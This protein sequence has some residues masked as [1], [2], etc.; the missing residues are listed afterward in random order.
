MLG[1]EDR[2]ADSARKVLEQSPERV[3]SAGRSA[4]GQYLDRIGGHGP[5]GVPLA[6][7]ARRRHG[8]CRL[9]GVTQ[10]LELG[11]EDFGKA[12]VEAADAGLG[13]RIG[14]S[15]G[16]RG[17]GLLGP[18]FS[19]RRDDH[20][21]SAAGRGDNPRN[22]LETAR[23]GHFQVEQNDVDGDR[24]ESFDGVLGR[25]GHSDDLKSAVAFDHSRQDCS[26]DHRIIDDHHPNSAR[27]SR[28]CLAV[29]RSGER[30]LHVG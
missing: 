16:Q 23:T 10:S 2:N 22:G 11:E 21:A 4:D 1:N 24:L 5:K 18:L 20:D 3:D 28:R 14:C 12:A 26:G 7:I 29:P 27:G 13:H 25:P 8:D 17:H 30:P 6:W 9:A 15:Q 19:Q